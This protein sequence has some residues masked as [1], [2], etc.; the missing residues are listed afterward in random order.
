MALIPARGGSKGIPRKNIMS[1][2]GKPLIAW[3]IDAA[4]TV[5]ELGRVIVSTDDEEIA[6]VARDAGAETP[7]MRP[8]D[9]AADDTPDFPVFLH[10]IE[11]LRDNEGYLP[12]IVVWLRPTS[13]LRTADDI[14]AALEILQLTG[15]DAVRSVSLTEHHPYWMKTLDKDGRLSPLITGHGEE[16]HPR[17]QMLPPAYHLN[18]LVDVIRVSSALKHGALFTGDVRGYVSPASRSHELDSPS[19]LPALLSALSLTPQ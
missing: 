5:R 6:G 9:L 4:K 10:A 8:S 13:P 3:S 19:D 16:S 11:W 1:V 7:F 12:E 17:R 2:A 14:R 18:G 15:A